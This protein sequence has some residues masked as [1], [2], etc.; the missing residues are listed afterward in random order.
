MLN[1]IQNIG[2]FGDGKWALNFLNTLKKEKNYKIS[3]ICCRKKIDKNIKIFS[4]RNRIDFLS[5][6]NVNLK[7]NTDKILSYNCDFLVSLSYDQIFKKELLQKYKDKILNCHAGD[8]PKYRGRNVLNWVLINGEKY[9][10][11]TIHLINKEI[12]LGKLILK[13]KFII[14]DKYNYNDLLNI[15][16]KECQYVLLNGIKK[17]VKKKNK[18]S[19]KKIIGKGSYY[20]KR[21]TG[22]ELIDLS[23]KN[24]EILNFVRALAHPGPYA[25]VKFN[26]K[27]FRIKKAKIY[28]KS[29]TIINKWKINYN[30]SWI[31]LEK[32][33]G[34][35]RMFYI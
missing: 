25:R 29:K 19:F 9:F 1:E 35:I 5:F 31:D 3:F 33:D 8:L 30:K 23:K 7:K 10:A 20:N 17:Y 4:K 21:K 13:K 34:K 2:F 22:D 27:E 11:I 6:Q 15:A 16:N 14:K 26:N 24:T 12:D 32:F 28:M 18:N